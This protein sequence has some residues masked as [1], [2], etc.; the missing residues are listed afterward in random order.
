MGGVLLAGHSFAPPRRS[1]SADLIR[2][3]R[4]LL[5]EDNIINQTVAR[6]VRKCGGAGKKGGRSLLQGGEGQVEGQREGIAESV[7]LS[8]ST[9]CA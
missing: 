3:Q 8:S 4:A 9:T 2:G 5:V 7:K 6:K 1:I